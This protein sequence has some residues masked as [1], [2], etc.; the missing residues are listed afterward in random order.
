MIGAV[1]SSSPQGLRDRIIA[2]VADAARLPERLL[3]GADLELSAV[4][5]D[6]LA[7]YDRR[8]ARQLQRLQRR[9]RNGQRY[10]RQYA[11]RG[12]RH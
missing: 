9:A 7:E 6:A 3:T 5:E 1:Q 8:F 10:H 2:A 4:E 12:R 11:N